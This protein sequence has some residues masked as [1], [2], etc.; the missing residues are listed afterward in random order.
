MNLAL[1]KV[2]WMP[3][4]VR[5][6]PE[7]EHALSLCSMGIIRHLGGRRIPAGGHGRIPLIRIG[8]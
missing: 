8:G 1:S 7:A 5:A 3:G 6:A 2:C 4:A